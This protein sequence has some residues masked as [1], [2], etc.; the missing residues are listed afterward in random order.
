MAIKTKHTDASQPMD[1]E[2]AR[3]LDEME[4]LMDE[5]Q[6]T[7]QVIRSLLNERD[8][9]NATRPEGYSETAHDTAS[10]YS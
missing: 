6:N 9:L 8:L 3:I 7:M 10:R 1:V 2:N 5:M 4:R